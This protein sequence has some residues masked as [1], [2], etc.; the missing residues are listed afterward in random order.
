MKR[1]PPGAGLQVLASLLWIGQAA[2]I[3][4][5]VQ[6]MADGGRFDAVWLPAGGV[7]GLGLVRAACEAAGT[8]RVFAQARGLLSQLRRDLQRKTGLTDPAH[9][10]LGHQL[11]GPHRC[12]DL[13]DLRLAPDEASDGTAEITR[14]RVKRP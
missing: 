11:M 2:L 6:G 4:M 3:A 8:R 14:S 7:L 12:F 10:G 13:G 1:L 9:P 5:A